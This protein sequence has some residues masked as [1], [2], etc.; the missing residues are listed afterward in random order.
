M[1]NEVYEQNVSLFCFKRKKWLGLSG[2]ESCRSSPRHP[3]PLGREK[4]VGGGTEDLLSSVVRHPF[5]KQ[6]PSSPEEGLLLKACHQESQ[7]PGETSESPLPQTDKWKLAD[8][9]PIT[10]GV[11]GVPQA[12]M[13]CPT[14]ANTMIIPMAA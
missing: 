6:S 4:W 13:L 14:R 5:H 11:L 10:D 9:V 2:Q 1:P 3:L 8:T 12:T 7:H